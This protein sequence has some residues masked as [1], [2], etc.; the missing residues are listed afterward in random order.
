[1]TAASDTTTP[2]NTPETSQLVDASQ[3]AEASSCAWWSCSSGKKTFCSPCSLMKYVLWALVVLA[4]V[5]NIVM[6]MKNKHAIKTM[7]NSMIQ[8]VETMNKDMTTIKQEIATSLEEVTLQQQAVEKTLKEQ[9]WLIG[10]L[11][12][13]IN[14]SF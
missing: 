11:E 7:S 4:L 12:Q 8:Q 14:N 9:D 13:M 2:E 10:A 6:T 5:W 3:K 1:M